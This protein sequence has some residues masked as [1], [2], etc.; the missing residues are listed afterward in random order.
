MSV[1]IANKRSTF[2]SGHILDTL[3]A[4]GFIAQLS[5]EEETYEYLRDPGKTFYI[6]F[7]PTAD[8]LHIGHLLQMVVMR[9]FQDAGHRPIVLLGGGT[10]MIGDPSGRTDLRQVL[11]P[12]TIEYNTARFREQ[13]SI[14]LDFSPGKAIIENNARWLLELNYVSFLRDIGACFSVNKMLTAEAYKLRLEKGLTFLEFNYML[15][16]AYD[17]L[18]LYRRHGCRLQLGGDDQWS[19]ILAGV[20]LIRR[21]EQELA[22]AVTTKLLAAAGGAKMGKTAAGAVWLD[23]K[24]TSP[25]DFY[26]YWRNIEDELVRERL[27][28]LTFLPVEMI[29]ELTA[30][31]GAALNEAKRVLALEVTRIV[32]GD[33]AAEEADK[34]ARALFSGGRADDMKT[35]TIT[36]EE[37][38]LPLIDLAVLSG[39]LPS[40]SEARRLIKQ[41]GL[42][43]NDEKV[44]DGFSPLLTSDFNQGEVILRRGK[45]NYL[46]LIKK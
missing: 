37:A 12:E 41:G 7:D 30:V 17:F 29:D 28:R 14:L 15:L 25:F 10:G 33:E 4:R 20:D 18:E 32:H 21:K 40:K 6:G 27:L 26:Q 13:M 34:T 3:K 36:E 42:F 43:V 23:A 45:K 8:S 16:Q 22:F 1:S 38:N 5:H 24:K 46:R 35:F 9:H 11:T 2:M 44:E 31:E 39:L 19:N